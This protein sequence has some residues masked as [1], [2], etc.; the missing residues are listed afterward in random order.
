MSKN[1]M[2]NGK[3]I[4]NPNTVKVLICS[5]CGDKYIKTRNRQKVCI[6]CLVAIPVK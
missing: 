6:R 3:W 5:S 2:K 1:F 4:D